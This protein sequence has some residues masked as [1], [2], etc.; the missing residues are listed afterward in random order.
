M[1]IEGIRCC[2]IGCLVLPHPTRVCLH[3]STLLHAI[4]TKWKA[5]H[6][7]GEEVWRFSVDIAN[8]PCCIL[9]CCMINLQ[10]RRKKDSYS[11]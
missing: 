7:L 2:G 9:T 1:R 3:C 6:F 4:P 8:F 11:P 10:I 5:P